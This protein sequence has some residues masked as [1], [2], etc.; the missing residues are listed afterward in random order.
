MEGGTALVLRG[1]CSQV[2][3]SATAAFTFPYLKQTL[4]SF[5]QGYSKLQ[6]IAGALDAGRVYGSWTNLACRSIFHG[7]V[8]VLV[9]AKGASFE[10]AC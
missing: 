1:T 8:F 9:R 6:G 10:Q 5:P 2:H 3:N 4:L 7:L